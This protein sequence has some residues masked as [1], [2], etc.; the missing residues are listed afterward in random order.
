V[1]S[2]EF[3]LGGLAL[4]RGRAYVMRG[5]SRMSLDERQYVTLEDPQSGERF[6]VPADEAHPVSLPP[7]E[8]DPGVGLSRER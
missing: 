3:Q 8:L 6:S 1:G 5:F 4:H 7:E 2:E